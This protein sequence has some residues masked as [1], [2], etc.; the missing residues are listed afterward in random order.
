M[1]KVLGEAFPTR[2]LR[3]STF[4]EDAQIVQTVQKA[5]QAAI[6]QQR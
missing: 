2:R 5:L 1:A 6:P 4:L 3:D